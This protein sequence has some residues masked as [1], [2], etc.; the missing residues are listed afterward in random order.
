MGR[1]DQQKILITGAGSGIG[2][3]TALAFAKE[4]AHIIAVD[5]GT[6][7][8][9]ETAELITAK[10]GSCETH[11]A[12]VSSEKAMRSL[13][14]MVH[15]AHGAIDVLVNN[16]GIGASGRFLET[17]IET[18]DKVH[19]VNV[20][21]VMLGCKLFIPAMVERGHGHVVNTASMAGYF[22][23][24]DLP[25]YAASKFAVLGFSEALRMDLKDQGIGV[26]AIC[27]GVINTNIVATTVAEGASAKW[28]EGAVAFYKKRNYG[29]EKVA[30]AI[31]DAVR[32]NRAVVPV[33]PEAWAG[34][35]LKRFMPGLA[36]TLAASP[37]PFMK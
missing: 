22:A 26:T 21:G 30:S 19:A 5:V 34:Y 2:R 6:A 25:V 13:A 23:A 17:S 28:Q 3:A 27:P 33:S 29:P 20:R 18:W 7:S 10:G 8:V 1:F 11:T 4:G 37:L 31:V 14:D 35:Y 32:H 12:D 9:K 16:A 36:R 15:A 24:P